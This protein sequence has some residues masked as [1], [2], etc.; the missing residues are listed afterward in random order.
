M[1]MKHV[2]QQQFLKTFLKVLQTFGNKSKTK[3]LVIFKDFR[4]Q[5]QVCRLHLQINGRH[6]LDNYRINNKR[7]LIEYSQ[8]MHFFIVCLISMRTKSE[9]Y[10]M[11]FNV[12]RMS[13]LQCVL[14]MCSK[15]LVVFKIFDCLFNMATQRS[16]KVGRFKIFAKTHRQVGNF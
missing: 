7:S 5:Y 8:H 15:Q 3:L 11:Y 12:V 16:G 1:V 2:L 6:D 13:Y 9:F 10:C 4:I 14:C